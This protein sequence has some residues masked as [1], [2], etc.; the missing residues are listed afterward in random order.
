MR[1]T[2]KSWKHSKWE[3]PSD[4]NNTTETTLLLAKDCPCT[5]QCWALQAEK[6]RRKK[7]R[8]NSIPIVT[9]HN[10][11]FPDPFASWWAHIPSDDTLSPSP[12]EASQHSMPLADK[13][14]PTENPGMQIFLLLLLLLQMGSSSLGTLTSKGINYEGMGSWFFCLC[15]IFLV[16]VMIAPELHLILHGNPLLLLVDPFPEACP[17]EL[18]ISLGSISV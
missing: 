8:A 4:T 6:M 16:F 17:L 14:K 5:P 1:E 10:R 18:Q 2:M 11:P 9:K 15:V 12:V 13:K 3:A 7:K